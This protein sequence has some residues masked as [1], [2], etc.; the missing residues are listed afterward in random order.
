MKQP[1]PECGKKFEPKGIGIHMAAHN[2]HRRKDVTQKKE[3]V[4]ALRTIVDGNIDQL[5]HDLKNHTTAIVLLYNEM[6]TENRHLKAENAR[7]TEWC[8]TMRKAFEGLEKPNLE[9]MINGESHA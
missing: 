5:T 9:H 3:K 4:E 7:L 6:K 1:C 2:R 8:T